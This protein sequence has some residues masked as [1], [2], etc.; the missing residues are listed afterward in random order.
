M[1]LERS[2]D[3]SRP[4]FIDAESGTG[5]SRPEALDAAFAHASARSMSAVAERYVSVYEEA[6]ETAKTPGPRVALPYTSSVPGADN[7]GQPA[8]NQRG[9]PA[10]GQA[11]RRRVALVGAAPT[12]GGVTRQSREVRRRGPQGGAGRRGCQG[13]RPPERQRQGHRSQEP[14]RQRG[15]SADRQVAQGQRPRTPQAR[16]NVAGGSVA[17]GTTPASA[18]DL[19]PPSAIAKPAARKIGADAA[20]VLTVKGR[21][22]GR[23]RALTVAAIPA[24][25]I[26]VLVIAVGAG[27]GQ[28]LVGLVVAVVLGACAWAGVWFGASRLLLGRL[29]GR[30]RSK[31]RTCRGRPIWW[32]GCARPWA[33]RCPQW[34]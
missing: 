27:V 31:T 19:A 9:T 30:L 24:L 29:G 28:V 5:G 12:A 15:R 34:C 23:G 2:S 26:V 20:N 16:N 14:R 6:I 13:C 7:S 1:T 33:F 4:H 25:V 18:R 22:P 17:S 21:V 32:T 3:S 11:A 10:V 8:G